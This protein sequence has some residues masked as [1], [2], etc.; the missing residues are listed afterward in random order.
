VA[1]ARATPIFPSPAADLEPEIAHPAD[2]RA[3][4]VT[5]WAPIS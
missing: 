4:W 1:L 5:Q 3:A 2:P